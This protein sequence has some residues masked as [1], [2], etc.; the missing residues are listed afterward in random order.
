MKKLNLLIVLLLAIVSSS[1]SDPAIT[2]DL[3]DGT[4]IF[5]PSLY[6][7]EQYLVSA[8]YPNPT[9]ADLDKHIILA[10]HGYSATTFEWQEFVDWSDPSSSY[11]VSQVLLDGHGR[12]YQSFKASTWQDWSSA[13]TKEY[14][15]LVAL[16]YTKISMVGSSTGGTLILELISSGYFNSH[17]PPKNLFLVDAI[18]VPSVKLQSVVGLIGPMIVFTEADQTA[19]ENKYWYRFR[20]QETITELNNVMRVVRKDLESGVRLPTGTY[21]KEFHSLHDPVA[22]STSSV[23]IYKGLKTSTGAN[24]DVQ[25][26]DSDIHVFTRLNLRSDTTP[27]QKANQLD[28]FSQIAIKL[29]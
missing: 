11:E 29:K 24:I 1:C 21:L 26:M 22:S 7:P 13:I 23:L 4:I 28:A 20:P 9:A 6:N 8:K 15:K 3:L 5:D 25:L 10:V 27:L 19:E 14:E 2:N 18:V 16:G 17:L 12:D